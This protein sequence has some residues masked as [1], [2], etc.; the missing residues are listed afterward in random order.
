MTVQMGSA[1]QTLLRAE[2]KDRAAWA[3]RTV[4]CAGTAESGTRS[5]HSPGQLGFLGYSS[6][7]DG[8]V[9][10][11]AWAGPQTGWEPGHLP[12]PSLPPPHGVAGQTATDA[13]HTQ[14]QTWVPLCPLCKGDIM[15]LTHHHALFIQSN[16]FQLP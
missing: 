7:S 1:F 11:A 15:T 14:L 13:T 16:S 8:L 9:Q 10:A 2:S 6:Y 3:P 12:E 5:G 4:T